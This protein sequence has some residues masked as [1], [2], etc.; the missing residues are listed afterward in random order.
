M[1]TITTTP[2]LPPT[3]ASEGPLPRAQLARTLMGELTGSYGIEDNGPVCRF[4]NVSAETFAHYAIYRW[5]MLDAELPESSYLTLSLRRRVHY[6]FRVA[7]R[8]IDRR[9][10]MTM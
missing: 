1:T 5:L 7:L 4:L 2:D 6:Q 10:K 9:Q 3:V 8:L